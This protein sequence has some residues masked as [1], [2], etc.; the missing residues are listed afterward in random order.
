MKE[1]GTT[2]EGGKI[3]EFTH[4][5]AVE[6]ARLIAVATGINV[7]APWEFHENFEFITKGLEIDGLFGAIRAFR[8]ANY[9]INTLKRLIEELD[10]VTS[11]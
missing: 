7:N 3:V 4:K 6:L 8:E 11:W 2:P 10:K 9:R 5:E 1:L